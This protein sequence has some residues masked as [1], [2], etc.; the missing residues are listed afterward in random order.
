MKFVNLDQGKDIYQE[1]FAEMIYCSFL[2]KCNAPICPLDENSIMDGLWYPD[3]EI[4]KK[5]FN[6]VWIKNQKKVKKKAKNKEKYFTVSML[7]R[8]I[9]IKTGILGLDYNA[10]YEDEC[11]WIDKHPEKRILT[12]EEKNIIRK[13][14]NGN[15]KDM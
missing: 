8:N 11:K 4:C 12:E 5:R 3:E 6:L 9:I 2:N 7:N 1:A 14:F 10:S 13:R 15:I